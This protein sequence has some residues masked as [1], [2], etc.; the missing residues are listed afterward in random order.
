MFEARSILRFWDTYSR[1][2]TLALMNAEQLLSVLRSWIFPQHLFSSD[3]P[4][5][6]LHRIDQQQFGISGSENV[7]PRSQ[8]SVPVSPD[9][10]S[11]SSGFG[12]SFLH[13]MTRRVVNSSLCPALVKHVRVGLHRCRSPQCSV[14]ADSRNIINVGAARLSILDVFSAAATMLSFSPPLL[15]VQRRGFL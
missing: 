7:I 9:R 4:R 12:T 11:A 10:H 3:F 2:L 5:L 1:V 14:A 15:Q 13:Q 6:A 8:F